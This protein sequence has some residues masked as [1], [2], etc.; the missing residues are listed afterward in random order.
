M[1]AL[2]IILPILFF[3]FTCQ[4][5]S[6]P[7]EWENANIVG[8]D[9]RDCMCCGGWLIKIGTDATDYQFFDLP[10]GSTIDLDPDRFPLRV[11]IKWEWAESCSET[12][13]INL[14]DIME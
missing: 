1:R 7:D 14:L 13:T 4:E 3:T 5:D 2:L 11:K 9:P 10:L 12:R 6:K 8:F